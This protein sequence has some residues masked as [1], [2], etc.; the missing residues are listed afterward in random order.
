VKIVLLLVLAGFA[1]GQSINC[2]NNA[3]AESSARIGPDGVVVVLVVH[4]ED[5]HTKN[6]HGCMANYTLRI[7]LPDGRS[8][9]AGLIP[10]MGFTGSDGE[11][12]RRLSVHLDGFSHDGKHIFGVI[13][14]GGTHPFIQVFDFARDGSHS[15]I[16]VKSGLARL[17]AVNCGPSFA[18]AGT[19][20]NSRLILEPD[21]ENRCRGNHRWTLDT[22]GNLRDMSKDEAFV[23][24]Y[25]PQ[26]R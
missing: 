18:V 6:S 19:N 10:R 17:K 1:S 23:S 9:A 8:G 14:E 12:G 20:G 11:C 22:Q 26:A 24:L 25:N 16:Q 5:D 2:A 15:E 4:S 7:T 21:T 3:T 13:S